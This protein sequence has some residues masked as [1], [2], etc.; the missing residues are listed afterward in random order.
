MRGIPHA[1][2]LRWC[3]KHSEKVAAKKG[4]A[5]AAIC[6]CE[7]R[8]PKQRESRNTSHKPVSGPHQVCL[9]V[10]AGVQRISMAAPLENP[11][12]IAI[13]GTL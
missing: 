12:R 5:T 1:G 2:Q 10:K 3:A 11:S 8:K 9:R 13:V 6:G 4:D 7:Q